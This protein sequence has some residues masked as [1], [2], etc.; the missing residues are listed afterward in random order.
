MRHKRDEDPGWT[1]VVH[2]QQADKQAYW[3]NFEEVYSSGVRLELN[4]VT[5]SENWF[6][7][8]KA[9]TTQE[10]CKIIRPLDL[11]LGVNGTTVA[12]LASFDAVVQLL[13]KATL[14]LTL[15][16]A[17]DV[18][19]YVVA[20]SW[21]FVD[22]RLRYLELSERCLTG[23]RPTVT[24]GVASNYDFAYKLRLF[25]SVELC[26]AT[27]SLEVAKSPCETLHITFLSSDDAAHWRSVLRPLLFR[28]SAEELPQSYTSGSSEPPT[29]RSRRKTSPALMP[30]RSPSLSPSG[31]SPMAALRRLS[32][33]PHNDL[34]TT[35]QSL[36]Q[37]VRE[38][39]CEDSDSEDTTED[40]APCKDD[41]PL[42]DDKV[43]KTLAE[44]GGMKFDGSIFEYPKGAARRARRLK[45]AIA[46]RT[47]WVFRDDAKPDTKAYGSINVLGAIVTFTGRNS[48]RLRF[49]KRRIDIIAHADDHESAVAATLVADAAVT[50]DAVKDG[51]SL[52]ILQFR[53]LKRASH[54]NC[55][56]GPWYSARA[57]TARGDLHLESPASRKPLLKDPIPLARVIAYRIMSE[58]PHRFE[59]QVASGSDRYPSSIFYQFHAPSLDLAM[60]LADLVATC[61]MNALAPETT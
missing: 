5:E 1:R 16:L 32:R 8:V 41:L 39:T 21:G 31:F 20:E 15:Q 24:G 29:P 12:S 26:E 59:L 2:K 54:D 42:D 49:S 46:G 18:G 35:A 48:L 19:P 7:S 37:A 14:P 43:K 25:G 34:Q 40:W 61:A 23:V 38:V 22:G 9:V 44:V 28:K 4:Q 51:N 47:L 13:Q 33:T 30:S 55:F 36:Q 53:I 60:D 10:L 17:R 6:A 52:G 50:Y 45:F 3:R 58:T 56:A 11:V 57:H 27:L